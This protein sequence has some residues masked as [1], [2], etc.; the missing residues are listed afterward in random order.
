MMSMSFYRDYLTL[1]WFKPGSGTPSQKSKTLQ[2]SLGLDNDQ[3]DDV[4]G[5][6]DKLII[7]KSRAKISD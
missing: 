6:N 4:D 7:T 3:T 1:K 5:L 2:R